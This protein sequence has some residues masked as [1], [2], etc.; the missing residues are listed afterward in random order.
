MD[1]ITKHFDDCIVSYT[2]TPEL[3]NAIFEKMLQFFLDKQSFSGESICQSD[4][5]QIDA[6]PLLAEIADDLFKFDVEW[7]E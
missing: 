3:R 4:S 6:A 7:K 1:K 5:C 2:D